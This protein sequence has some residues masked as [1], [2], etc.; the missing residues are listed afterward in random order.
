MLVGRHN[1]EA[2][3]VLDELLDRYVAFRP[4]E[5]MPASLR[6]PPLSAMGSPV[7]LANRFGGVQRM[8]SAVSAPH[9]EMHAA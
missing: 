1:P 5:L 7:E 3:A 4:D 9:D 6:V 2:R 8:R